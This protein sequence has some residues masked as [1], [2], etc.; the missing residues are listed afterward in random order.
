[1]VFLSLSRA[2]WL[3]AAPDT[4]RVSTR[5]AMSSHGPDRRTGMLAPVAFTVDLTGVQE[6][7]LLALPTDKG[8]GGAW[9]TWLEPVLHRG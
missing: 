4:G 8:N 3:T 9:S 1:M 7:E 2:F 6:L 5:H